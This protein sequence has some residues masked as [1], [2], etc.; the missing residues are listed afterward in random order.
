MDAA[1]VGV[2]RDVAILV[3]MALLLG[4]FAYRWLRFAKP[5][6]AWNWS[7][8]VDVRAF[9]PID[10]MVVA[11]I[12]SLL[13]G[14]LQAGTA[15]AAAAAPPQLSPEVLLLNAAVFLAFCA[16]LLVY[17]VVFRGLHPVEL[18]GLR[19]YKFFKVLG[20]AALCIVPAWFFVNI[21]GAVI[22][23]WMKTFWPNDMSQDLVEAFRNSDN[24]SAKI[25]TVFA[26]VII[27]PLVEEIIFRGFVYGVIKRYTDGYFAAICS[28][29]LF[30]TVHFHVG[31]LF[32][33]ALLALT[34]CLAYELTGSLLV[35]MIMHAIF[36]ATS[37]ALLVL[38]KGFS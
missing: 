25:L 27:A 2:L 10:V 36:N 9:N 32:P 19:R 33:L 24:L 14:G 11:A 6:L 18:F 23:E 7:G 38:F 8:H 37:L 31:S 5:A 1:T 20:L 12:A 35:P 3:G 21:S 17:L 13:L 16:A 15:A 4:L 30:A 28:A 29:L 22:G 26:A 34:F